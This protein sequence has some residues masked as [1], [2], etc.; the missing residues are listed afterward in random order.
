MIL[1]GEIHEYMA[2]ADARTAAGEPKYASMNVF[3]D[4]RRQWFANVQEYLRRWVAE[5]HDGREDTWTPG[6]RAARDSTGVWS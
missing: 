1:S 5:H 6:G 4:D 2:L 3:S